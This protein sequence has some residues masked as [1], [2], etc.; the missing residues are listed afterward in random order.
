MS[1]KL[2]TCWQGHFSL[3]SS[4][5]TAPSFGA[6]APTP[7]PT[8]VRS[9]NPIT[10]GAPADSDLPAQAPFIELERRLALAVEHQIRIP[11]IICRSR[12]VTRVCK[13]DSLQGGHVTNSSDLSICRVKLYGNALH[14]S[15]THHEFAFAER[16]RL[17]VLANFAVLANSKNELAGRADRC[18][19]LFP[20]S[21]WVQ[22]L[23]TGQLAGV[24]RRA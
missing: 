5:L 6:S 21:F 24:C 18:N 19:S 22:P 2:T 8:S 15:V 20:K 3:C 7:R 14:G 1:N 17:P 9:S 16:S 23:P 4:F 12:F 11:L 13:G 10:Y